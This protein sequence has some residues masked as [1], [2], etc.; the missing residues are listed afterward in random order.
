MKIVKQGKIK[1]DIY[2]ATCRKCESK[3]E[4]RKDELHSHWYD[5]RDNCSGAHG[6]CPVCCKDVNWYKKN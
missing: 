5:Q 6:D 2:K 1:Q 3:L 4:A